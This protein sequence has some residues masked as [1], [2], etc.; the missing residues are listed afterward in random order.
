MIYTPLRILLVSMLIFLL[1]S[2][3]GAADL[4]F[5]LIQSFTYFPFQP[6]GQLQ[7][8]KFSFSLLASYSNIFAIDFT[9]DY[10]N[11]MEYMS[12]TLFVRYGLTPKIALEAAGRV[13]IVYRGFLGSSIEWF[14]SAF[15]LPLARRNEYPR[16]IL[17]YRY[18]GYLFYNVSQ[19]WVSPL[20]LGVYGELARNGPFTLGGR[21]AVGISFQ[22]KPGFSS[23]KPFLITGL[24]TSYRTSGF[25][26]EADGYLSF[27]RQPSWLPGEDVRRVLYLIQG[28]AGYRRIA[29]GFTRK[30]SPFREGDQSHTGNLFFLEYRIGRNFTIGVM[31]D[32]FPFDTSP[33]IGFF[34]RFSD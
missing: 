14:H 20:V 4:E 2:S 28:K 32:F 21:L 3:L 33:D 29:L 30:S 13:S 15:S 23:S 26:C 34:F 24:S 27:F 18:K 11:D 12:Y 25:F 16:D 1:G 22:D 8:R 17:S 5:P 19:S 10:F 31:E 6:H 9:G 7:P